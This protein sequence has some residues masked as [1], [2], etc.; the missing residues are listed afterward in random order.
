MTLLGHLTHGHGPV[1]VV[2]LHEWLGDH[3]N[4]DPVL[5]YLPT[6]RATWLLADLRGYGLSREMAGAFTLDEAATDVLRL[7]DHYGHRRFLVVGHSMSGLIAQDLAA[8][9]PER[10][11][12][13]VALSPVPPSGFAADAAALAR[14]TA[15]VDDDAAARA[16]IDARVS[17]R[18]GH[19]WLD[20]KL[21]LCRRAAGRE[22]LLGYLRMFTTCDITERV[23]GLT[24]PLTVLAGAHDLPFYRPEALRSRLA[25]LW[26]HLELLVSAEAGHYAM[27]ETP[28]LVAALLERQLALY[29]YS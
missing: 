19:G 8:R 26:P 9:V 22:A 14:M 13:I 6:D 28:V 11:A 12:G 15:I 21:A 27:L 20:R 2:V 25:P 7:M 29:D 23:R 5:P 17:G 16:A 1:P 3:T 24:T 10:V 18:Y 4:Y